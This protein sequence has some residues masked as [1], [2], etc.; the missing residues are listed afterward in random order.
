[1]SEKK[2]P[3]I[4]IFREY[5]VVS[6]ATK[7]PERMWSECNNHSTNKRTKEQ[8]LL[9]RSRPSD[10]MFIPTCCS[11]LHFRGF[12]WFSYSP[13]LMRFTIY[14]MHAWDVRGSSFWCIFS[15]VEWCVL[16]AQW[17]RL[18]LCWNKCWRG[19][20]AQGR[21]PPPL[22]RIPGKGNL[23]LLSATSCVFNSKRWIYLL[24]FRA[25]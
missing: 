5:C 6:R 11:K 20:A 1:M 4:S 9:W 15:P 22:R 3:L 10:K 19:V 25:R 7:A 14:I 13:L 21:V 2:K 23:T 17:A 18:C 24:K 16:P 12:W 8:Q